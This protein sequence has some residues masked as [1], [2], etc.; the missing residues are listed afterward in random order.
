MPK[1]CLPKYLVL[2]LGCN[3]PILNSLIHAQ[4]GLFRKQINSCL[5]KH[6]RQ[7]RL[8]TEFYNPEEM[9]LYSSPHYWSFRSTLGVVEIRIQGYRISVVLRRRNGGFQPLAELGRTTR[10]IEGS[11]VFSLNEW[12][13]GVKAAMARWSK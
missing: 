6:A 4:P 7:T 13:A 5:K 2:G 1:F 12:I 10:T 11:E 3:A 9:S 8:R